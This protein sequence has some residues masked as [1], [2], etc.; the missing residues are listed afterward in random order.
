MGGPAPYS[1]WY[2]N[3]NVAWTWVDDDES[4]FAG[5]AS[6][7]GRPRCGDGGDNPDA[8]PRCFG[9]VSSGE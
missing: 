1:R 3:D 4:L 9:K 7:T 5:F 2:D 6:P 8:L